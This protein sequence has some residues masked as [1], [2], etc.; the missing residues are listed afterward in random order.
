MI[1]VYLLCAWILWCLLAHCVFM[2]W[3]TCLK[4]PEKLSKNGFNL[5]KTS[6]QLDG[7]HRGG[8][9]ERAENTTGAFKNG[10]AQGLNLMECD[11]H[12][13]R[14]GEDVVAHDATLSRLC[15]AEY[16]GQ[17]ISDYDFKDLPPFQQTIQ[18]HFVSE[19]YSL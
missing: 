3:C 14:D 17:R 2:R 11:V 16:A 8:G 1:V 9:C 4:R 19:P 12:L 15:G 5:S 6:W 13:S 7:A 18:Q 10:M